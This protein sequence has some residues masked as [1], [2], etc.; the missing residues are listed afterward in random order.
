MHEGPEADISCHPED[1]LV[2]P[3]RRTLILGASGLLGK[4]IVNRFSI[5][6][7]YSGK[8]ETIPWREIGDVNIGANAQRLSEYLS[9]K[10]GDLT[11]CDVIV[12][13]GLIKS[14]D[15]GALL[16]SNFEFPTNLIRGMWMYPGSRCMTFGTIHEKFDA[17]VSHNAYFMSKYRL[18]QWICEF[19]TSHMVSDALPGRI[20]H[21]RL[22]TLYGF[23]PHPQMFLGQMAE[24]LISDV[25]FKMS[26][27]E[28]LREYHHAED[29]AECVFR[30]FQRSWYIGPVLEISSGEAVRLKELAVAVF[31]EFHKDHLLWIGEIPAGVGENKSKTF[32]RSDPELLP[33]SRE[34][35][36]GVIETLRRYFQYHEAT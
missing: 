32:A 6:T 4:A 15:E 13:S 3:P 28:Q 21:L 29:I 1:G 18:S 23:P 31:R 34:T 2:C 22:H 10:L 9:T 11:D 26:S 12:A 8:V 30:L 27:G 24:A 36:A 19:V 5:E 20:L 35:I 25:P 16:Y 14:Q 7:Q 17:A 33:Y